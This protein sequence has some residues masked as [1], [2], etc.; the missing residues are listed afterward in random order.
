VFL[1]LTILVAVISVL[2]TPGRSQDSQSLGDLARQLQSQKS[3]GQPKTVITNDDLPSAS[4]V[5]IHELEKAVDAAASTKSGTDTSPLASLAHW[6]SVVK[7]ID[8]MDR[9]TLLKVALDGANPDFPGHRN[10]EEKLFAAKQT[11]VSQGEEY[12]QRARQL[13]EMAHAL[14]GAQASPDD[15][16][17]K[18]LDENLKRLVRESVGADV[19]FRTVIM[20]GRDLAHQVPAH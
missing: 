16:R 19:A 13:L 11:Y 17:V 10:W 3:T 2:S 8:S 5:T 9:A 20:E 1:R 4:P 18:E 12:I 15:P 7:E 6:E 14:K